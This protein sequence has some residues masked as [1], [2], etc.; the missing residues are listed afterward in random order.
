MQWLAHFRRQSGFSLIELAVVLLILTILLSLGIGAISSVYASRQ[1]GKTAENVDSLRTAL[2]NYLR[3]N[4][5]LPCP[6]VDFNAPDG[7]GEDD[8]ATANNATTTCTQPFGTVPYLALGLDRDV[9]LDG[10]DNFFTYM[11]SNTDD[12]VPGRNRD[13]TR[14]N[15]FFVG[16]DGGLTDLGPSGIINAVVAILSHGPNGSGAWTTKGTQNVLPDAATRPDELDNTNNDGDFVDRQPTGDAAAIGGP[17]DDLVIS[18]LSNDLLSPLIRDGALRSPEGL[19]EEQF[20]TVKQAALGQI[21][22]NA[23]QIPA[24]ANIAVVLSGGVLPVDPWG[25][26]LVFT[27][28]NPGPLTGA[29]PAD[30][31]P[32]FSITSNGPNRNL[33]GGG[34][35]HLLI[36]NAAQLRGILASTDCNNFDLDRTLQAGNSE[37]I[38]ITLGNLFVGGGPCTSAAGCPPDANENRYL[39]PPNGPLAMLDPWNTALDFK[40][41]VGTDYIQSD[42]PSGNAYTITSLGLNGVLGGGDDRTITITVDQIKGIIGRTGF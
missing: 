9:A 39:L 37:A 16:N 6:D 17:I 20:D 25:I 21:T 33:D 1:Y 11:V 32:M 27:Q 24:P 26:S 42:T 14:T 35:D 30:A 29:L 31:T 34:D 13:W 10:W 15:Q 2:G 4:G 8:R 38:G 22:S 5:H 36:F 19:L 41:V 40:R 18:I 12:G 23:C 3:K 7:T 28:S